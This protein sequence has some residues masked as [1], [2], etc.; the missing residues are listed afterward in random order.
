[1]AATGKKSSRNHVVLTVDGKLAVLDCLKAGAT[2]EKVAEEF[3][4]GCA[5]VGDLKK[6]EDKIQSFA[7]TMETLTMNKKECKVMWLA[8][9]DKLNEIVY[10]WFVQ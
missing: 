8:E 5:T 6:N 3:G 4:M 7:S 2:Q 9:N 1:M 10:L